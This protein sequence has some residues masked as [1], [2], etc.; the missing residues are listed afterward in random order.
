MRWT[1]RTGMMSYIET[2]SPRTFCSR[3]VTLS[4]RTLALHAP[5]VRLQVTNPREQVS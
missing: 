5:L 4:S 2:F 1:T 3:T